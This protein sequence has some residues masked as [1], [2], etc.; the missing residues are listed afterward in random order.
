M[1]VK[2]LFSMLCA[3]PVHGGMLRLFNDA[4]VPLTAVIY[5]ADGSI[6]GELTLNQMDGGSWSDEEG[7]FTPNRP[8]ASYSVQW[9][10][11]D[12]APYSVCERVAEGATV[13]AQGCAGM[14]SCGG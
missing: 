3:M 10:C 2:I 7:D 14:R 11:G 1:A 5:G 13:T 12:G 8:Q 6:A 4:P 9:L